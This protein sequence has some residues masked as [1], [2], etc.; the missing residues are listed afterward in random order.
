[1][2]NSAIPQIAIESNGVRDLP[3]EH[4]TEGNKIFPSS[5]RREGNIF[6][7]VAKRDAMIVGSERETIILPM[8]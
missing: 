6:K 5:S 1:M 3:S 7:K 8:G 2:L 4:Y